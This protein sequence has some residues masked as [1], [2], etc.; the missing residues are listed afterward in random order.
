MRSFAN[1][2]IPTSFSSARS[3]NTLSR[4][5]VSGSG[6]PSPLFRRGLCQRAPIITSLLLSSNSSTHATL[7]HD[8]VV[9]ESD[10]RRGNQTANA[11]FGKRGHRCWSATSCIPRAP[12][13]DGGRR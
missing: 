1:V 10:L 2:R 5:A 4:A 6:R 8:D 11:L 9:D 13:D 12:S 7:L 3:P